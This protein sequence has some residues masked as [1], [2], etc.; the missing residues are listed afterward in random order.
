MS[1]NERSTPR[2]EAHDTHEDEQSPV[3]D[4][5]DDD[6]FDDVDQGW[7][8]GDEA[9]RRTFSKGNVIRIELGYVLRWMR[10]E[11]TPKVGT[12]GSRPAARDAIRA[13]PK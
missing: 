1:D 12:D 10:E 11:P 9:H 5:D 13:A 8:F 6:G 4:D 2:N 7:I 3:A